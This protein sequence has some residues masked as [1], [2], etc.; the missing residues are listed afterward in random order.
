M[1]YTNDIR[2]IIGREQWDEEALKNHLWVV[3]GVET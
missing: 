1:V 2:L 3:Y